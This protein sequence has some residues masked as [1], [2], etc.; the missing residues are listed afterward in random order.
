MED[1][2][3]ARERLGEMLTEYLMLVGHIE[4]G[5]AAAKANAND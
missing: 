4:A 2:L 3:E 5:V 1:A